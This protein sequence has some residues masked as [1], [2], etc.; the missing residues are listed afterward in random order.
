MITN[1]CDGTMMLRGVEVPQ[2]Q[3][4][5]HSHHQMAIIHKTRPSIQQSTRWRFL[6]VLC[7]L[8]CFQSIDAQVCTLCIDGS[9]PPNSALRIDGASCQDLAES[10]LSSV[11]DDSTCAS[12]QAT[13]GV[14]CGCP[15]PMLARTCRMCGAWLLPDP[16]FRVTPPAASI[17]SG[18]CL[19][20]EFTG[21][22]NSNTDGELS[23][24]SLRENYASLCCDASTRPTRAPTQRPSL[25]PPTWN[26]TAIPTLTP[27]SLIT[28]M[29]SAQPTSLPTK[30]PTTP[31]L[32]SPTVAP[33]PTLTPSIK[34]PT[35]LPTRTPVFQ[36]GA[37]FSGITLGLPG[38]ELLTESA[39]NNFE[40]AL[41]GWYASLYEPDG[42]T[43]FL[44][45][46]EKNR[47][48]QPQERESLRRF[49]TRVLYVDQFVDETTRLTTITYDQTVSFVQ[50]QE[51]EPVDVRQLLLE[52]F[53]DEAAVRQL[54]DRLLV[55]DSFFESIDG[56]LLG[57]PNVPPADDDSNNDNGDEINLGLVLGVVAGG[58]ILLAIVLYLATKP[59][60]KE[61]STAINHPVENKVAEDLATM[62]DERHPAAAA[63]AVE[64]EDEEEI[65]HNE[66]STEP[67]PTTP[68]P[69]PIA[70][71]KPHVKADEEKSI[72]TNKHEYSRVKSP[73]PGPDKPDEGYTPTVSTAS[74]SR[75]TTSGDT[76]SS[77]M[78]VLGL[79]S[80][81]NDSHSQEPEASPQETYEVIVPPGKLGVVIDTPDEGP[82][83]VFAVKNTSPL[84]G[85]VEVGDFLIQ[86]DDEDV[87]TYSAV[88]V[89]R[90]IGVKA[91]NPERRFVLSRSL[92]MLDDNDQS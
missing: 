15:D 60:R 68:S 82:P 88:K 29:P 64:A 61:E 2:I 80:S 39:Q 71:P 12:I 3:R 76:S 84:F 86:V 87:S 18:T 1:E 22:E 16:E 13:F 47:Y 37:S 25:V 28:G 49:Q 89:S 63:A 54:L 33:F 67:T 14:Y 7:M 20:L 8:L 23:C 56:D 62:S 21:T 58:L 78:G 74:V 11:S 75:R 31:S 42:L 48:L 46:Q 17:E 65:P 66:F 35:A 45:E 38:V 4:H 24:E 72:P 26:P 57:I 69:A 79:E 40:S 27:S 81:A 70:P 59:S 44:T 19:Q 41:Q 52:P 73:G 77:W 30:I 83:T 91:K 92:P 10:F 43:R 51:E 53:E 5:Y 36:V 50:T 90:L 34:V 55:S 85:K 6:V 32:N 9:D